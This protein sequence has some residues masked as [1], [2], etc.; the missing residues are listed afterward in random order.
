M[1]KYDPG[2]KK[3]AKLDISYSAPG[4]ACE[5]T[6]HGGFDNDVATLTTIMNRIA[7]H[8]VPSPPVKDELIGY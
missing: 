3:S 4:G 1:A 7:G 8:Q 6:S 5:S 2:L